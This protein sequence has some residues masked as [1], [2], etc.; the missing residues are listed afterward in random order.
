MLTPEEILRRGRLCVL[1]LA[2]ALSLGCLE[3]F[4][5]ALSVIAE[6]SR[7]ACSAQLSGPSSTQLNCGILR[8]VFMPVLT[9]R[10]DI[11]YPP[12]P[13][14]RS[15]N[16]FEMIRIT[17]N[18]I[19]A[20]MIQGKAIRNRAFEEF[21]CPAVGGDAF[22]TLRKSPIALIIHGPY[23]IPAPPYGV[24]GYPIK[25]KLLVANVS[26]FPASLEYIHDAAN[27]A[28]NRIC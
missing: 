2:P 11:E 19:S 1:L 3:S 4:R 25:D 18:G 6:P 15:R 14:L 16:G 27:I 17:A 8:G 12:A 10:G 23:P 9:M 26:D 21:V 28:M 20:Q 22:F 13:V 7:P 5:V 24:N